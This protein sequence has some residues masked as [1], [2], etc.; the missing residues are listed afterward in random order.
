M[1]LLAER[2]DKRWTLCD[3]VSFVMMSESKIAE[4]L[5]TDHNFEQAGFA[6]LLDR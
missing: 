1:R 6:R 5:T 3:A 2:E 4:A